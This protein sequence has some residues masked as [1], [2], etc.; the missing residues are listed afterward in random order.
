MDELVAQIDWDGD[1]VFDE[2]I[3]LSAGA[4][5]H[6]YLDDSNAGL[7]GLFNVSV[8][9]SDGVDS[10]TA[11]TSADIENVLPSN[12][13]AGGPYTIGEGN[14]LTL[15]G[16]ADDVQGDQ[17]DLQFFWEIDAGDGNGYQLVAGPDA[18]FPATGQN[19]SNAVVTWQQLVALGIDDGPSQFNLRMRVVD[20]GGD[21]DYPTDSTVVT[22][23]NVLSTLEIEVLSEA[24]VEG[25]VVAVEA[26]VT[27]DDADLDAGG[28]TFQWQ[29]FQDGVEVVGLTDSSSSDTFDFTPADN[30]SYNIH[31]FANDGTATVE[32]V[33]TVEV[34]NVAPTLVSD[35]EIT[36]TASSTQIDGNDVALFELGI[37]NFVGQFN[38]PAGLN[39]SYSGSVNIVSPD[40]SDIR[41]PVAIDDDN[42]F[43]FSYFFDSPGEYE[44]VFEI[45][46]EDGGLVKSDTI[47][48]SVTPPLVV[49]NLVR[50]SSGDFDGTGT[51]R[52]DLAGPIGI[53]FSEHVNVNADALE[54][55]N[56]TSPG[57]L[58]DLAGLG[59]SY[60]ATTYTAT[61][62]LSTLTTAL[63]P[64]FYDVRIDGSSVQS[65]VTEMMLNDGASFSETLYVA[66]PGDT[67]LDGVVTLSVPNLLT[68]I[69]TG[70]AAIAQRNVG[71]TNATWE[72]GDF[73]GDGVVTLSVPDLL[74][75][76]N[77]GD[78][79]VAMANA[80]RDVRPP[81]VSATVSSV[82]FDFVPDLAFSTATTVGGSLASPVTSVAA[83]Q[84]V[85]VSLELATPPTPVVTSIDVAPSDVVLSDA[86]LNDVVL[87]EF[88]STTSD[89]GLE[90][91]LGRVSSLY[92]TTPSAGFVSYGPM[93]ER[94]NETESELAINQLPTLSTLTVS[95]VDVAAQ[96][97]TS[98]LDRT[99]IVTSTSD[100]QVDG[101]LPEA[102]GLVDDQTV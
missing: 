69:N 66:I 24:P 41:L 73:D 79:A 97:T 15:N 96:S 53:T 89:D 36:S 80:G 61:W 57:T 81:T 14:D 95:T 62:D 51:R 4:L 98:N 91:G 54:V 39:D 43:G 7:G 90:S 19:G 87:S 60:D 78:V 82:I 63:E 67:N 94:T 35:I 72:Q 29:V 27:N 25:S 55:L 49:A 38:D 34:A 21:V 48:V 8:E 40:G 9:I 64:G 13:N 92:L 86:A 33:L 12:L 47:S 31:L 46:D 77:T 26:V 42:G 20:D 100:R 99:F 23:E 58:V 30:G 44:V 102:D 50:E 45:D 37:L 76:T 71:T 6:V 88:I 101:V 1:G 65:A 17:L 2:T 68:R 5:E 16:S 3:S 85:P 93:P 22:V 10:T 56:L 84:P 11:T 52:P 75:R 70:D 32:Q 28:Y 74:N 83:T 18:G 59:F